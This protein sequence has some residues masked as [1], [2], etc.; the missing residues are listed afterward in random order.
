MKSPLLMSMNLHQAQGDHHLHLL[1]MQAAMAAV[2][3]AHSLRCD[4]RK[5]MR[6][7]LP[8]EQARGISA[9]QKKPIEAPC[10]HT[11]SPNHTWLMLRRRKTSRIKKRLQDH[12]RIR[13]PDTIRMMH[14]TTTIMA[15]CSLQ[16]KTPRHL[17]QG[18]TQV[19]REVLHGLV[20]TDIIKSLRQPHSI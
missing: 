12:I 10:P 14:D 9:H 16:W 15:R 19:T 6:F 20:I 18:T 8:P 11:L 5:V 4:R 3:L 2:R 17:L 13:N 7:H 1:L